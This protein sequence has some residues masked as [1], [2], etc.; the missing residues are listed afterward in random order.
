MEEMSF[1]VLAT[2]YMFW[3]GFVGMAAGT[4]FFLV[5]RNSLN[6]EYRSTATV[7][8]LVTF[9]AAVHYFFMKDAVGTSGLISEIQGFPTEIRYIDWLITTPLLLVKFP[10]LLSLKGKLGNILLTK[11]LGA[12]V[13]MIV[14]GYIG[15]TSIN[16]AGGFTQLGLWSFVIGTLAWIYIIFLLYTNVTEAANKKPAPIKKALL[17]MRL[18]IL[19]GWAIYPIGYVVTLV[20]PGIEVLVVRELI[21]NFADLINKVGFGLIAFFAVKTMSTLSKSEEHTKS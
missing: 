12:D 1:L 3:V 16:A 2:Q 10:L 8:A 14:S 17:N 9:V 11:L 19:I 6:P 4:L 15:E 21:Y 7:A 20:S 13:I 5:E 18:F